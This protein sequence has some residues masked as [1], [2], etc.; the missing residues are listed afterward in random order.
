MDI[1][2]NL[3]SQELSATF[4]QAIDE[5]NEEALR[6][7][8]AYMPAPL[9]LG[10]DFG[11]AEIHHGNLGVHVW[12]IPCQGIW[13][14]QDDDDPGVM[15]DYPIARPR[16]SSVVWTLL[17]A[18]AYLENRNRPDNRG[19]AEFNLFTGPHVGFD[20]I[21][22]THDVICIG[23]TAWQTLG[24]TF[25]DAGLLPD[26]YNCDPIQPPAVENGPTVSERPEPKVE[27]S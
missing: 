8:N 6:T 24:S 12:S 18:K 26:D 25:S 17:A 13:T 19:F 22:W 16:Y 14:T 9:P 1:P 20:D 5:L 21:D 3:D 4:V 23:L 10:S 27:H 2:R 7:R 15:V 11:E